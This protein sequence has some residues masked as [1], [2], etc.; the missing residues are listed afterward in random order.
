MPCAYF[1]CTFVAKTSRNFASTVRDVRV[2]ARRG[3]G[4]RLGGGHA[5]TA[6]LQFGDQAFRLADV[7]AFLDDALGGEVL[8]FFIGQTENHFR[9]ADGNPAFAHKFLHR[10]RQ[11]QQARG[12]GHHG[13]AFAD[14]ERDFFLRELKLFRELRVTVRFF[15]ARSDSRAEDFR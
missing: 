11:F 10:R 2:A 9:V 14:L 7:Q 3:H 8:I 1:N 6:R 15:D 4:F 5:R 13:A 12:V